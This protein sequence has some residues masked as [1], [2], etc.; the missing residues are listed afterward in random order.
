[1]L[2]VDGEEAMSKATNQPFHLISLDVMLSYLNGF[3]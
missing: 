2:H 1:M 3:V